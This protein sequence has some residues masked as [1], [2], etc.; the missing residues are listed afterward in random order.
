VSHPKVPFFWAVVSLDLDLSPQIP[1][2]SFL[3]AEAI[4]GRLTKATLNAKGV[5]LNMIKNAVSV[6]IV[7]NNGCDF[8]DYLILQK[9][10]PTF[11]KKKQHPLQPTSVAPTD[12]VWSADENLFFREAWRW[13]QTGFGLQIEKTRTRIQKQRTGTQVRL[14]TESTKS[15]YLYN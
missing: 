5:M 2:T 11:S 1:N 12:V 3:K 9:T 7:C 6:C 13:K 15:H 14:V 4:P 10:C 8:L